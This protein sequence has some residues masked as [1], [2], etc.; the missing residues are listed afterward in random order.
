[1]TR[2]MSAR[3]HRTAFRLIAATVAILSI[4][5]PSVSS[6]Q[7]AADPDTLVYHQITDL[8]ADVYGVADPE[9][10][11][12]GQV[13]VF[14]D[15]PGTGDE[16]TPNRIFTMDAEGGPLTE[17]DSYKTLCFCSSLVD[18][19][20]DGSVVVSSDSIQLR[21]ADQSGAR[22]LLVLASNEL[23]PHSPDRRWRHRLLSRQ[24]W[25]GHRRRRSHPPRRLGH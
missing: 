3:V 13:A 4:F 18:I 6:A 20:E 5:A 14:A 17:V 23:R 11:A 24:S 19:N 1:M 2:S 25:H 7:V 16:T 9:L 10:S 22:E 21:V 8:G 12:D 15:A